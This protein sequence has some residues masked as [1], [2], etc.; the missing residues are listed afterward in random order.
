MNVAFPGE[1]TSHAFW[2]IAGLMLVCI[3]GLVGFFRYKRWL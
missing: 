2:A 1:G 3:V